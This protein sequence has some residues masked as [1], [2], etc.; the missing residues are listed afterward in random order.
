MLW[1][2]R[3]INTLTFYIIVVDINAQLVEASAKHEYPWKTYCP[4]TVYIVAKP[5]LDPE[6]PQN[7]G[8]FLH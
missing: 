1:K 2:L 4:A 3:F 5:H 8:V 7:Q 6:L